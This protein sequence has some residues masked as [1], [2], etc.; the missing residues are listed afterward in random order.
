MKKNV[1]FIYKWQIIN[2]SLLY[3]IV[4]EKC[5]VLE[6]CHFH[7]HFDCH[8]WQIVSCEKKIVGPCDHEKEL[9]SL[10]DKTIMTKCLLIY[11]YC[12]EFFFFILLACLVNA[13][14]EVD[15]SSMSDSQQIFWALMVW[16]WGDI[17]DNET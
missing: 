10:P 11:H 12:F 5:V 14:M 17:C 1:G 4:M 2:Y 7:I 6:L 8:A 13:G 15:C 9:I 3:M 16:L